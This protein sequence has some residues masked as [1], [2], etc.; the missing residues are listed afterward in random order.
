ML[1]LTAQELRELTGHRRS[2]E[3]RH[4]VRVIRQVRTPLP[5]WGGTWRNA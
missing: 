5:H 3:A 2:D 4:R 1:T